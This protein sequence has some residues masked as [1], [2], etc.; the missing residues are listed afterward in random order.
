[1]GKKTWLR[2]LY[3]NGTADKWR[4]VAADRTTTQTWPRGSQWTKVAEPN[5]VLGEPAK[6]RK[7]LVRVPRHLQP[8]EYVLSFR[9]D[10]EKTAQ[11]VS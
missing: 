11:V 1:M 7:D 6:V 4:T 10:C 9:W 5:K 2:T 8:G 3:K